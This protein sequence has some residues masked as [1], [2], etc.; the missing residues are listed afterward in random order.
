MHHA[1]TR[2]V[3]LVT[4]L[5][6]VL[7]MASGTAASQSPPERA[8]FQAWQ[9]QLVH[10]LSERGTADTL[11]TAAVLLPISASIY[12][13]KASNQQRNS[14]A[15]KLASKRLQLLERA[16]AMAPDAADIAALAL[17]VCTAV[18]GC[19][20]GKHAE[21]LHNAAPDDARYL[22]PA[23]DEAVSQ[24]DRDKVSAILQSMADA[25]TFNSWYS[26]TL[27]RMQRGIGDIALPAL[28]PAAKQN[29]PDLPGPRR[30]AS[31]LGIAMLTATGMPGYSAIDK[32]CK[33]EAPEFMVRQE[34]CRQIGV[35]LSRDSSL[36]TAEIGL[37]F[38]RRAARDKS[39][40]AVATKASRQLDWQ[41]QSWIEVIAD[42][43][44][45]PF[46]SFQATLDKDGEIPGIVALLKDHNLPT[47]PPAGWTS[48]REQRERARQEAPAQPS[49]MCAGKP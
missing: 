14:A 41:R 46:E 32:A 34:A 49:S 42:G 7:A 27:K 15:N 10:Q 9:N 48:P 6:P 3:L 17:Q 35:L 21:R 1:R 26:V 2:R 20:V 23:L 36:M 16:A 12:D 31:A 40:L 11:T 19:D 8:E 4:I 47:T 30:A 25:S 5:M 13:S 18:P 44:V 37:V 45:D 39:D 33:K 29:H 38:W 43:A 28:P 24:Q 22:L